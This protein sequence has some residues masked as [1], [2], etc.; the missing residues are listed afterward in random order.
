MNWKPAAI[1]SSIVKPRLETLK[2]HLKM[3]TFDIGEI[4]VDNMKPAMFMRYAR[5]STIRYTT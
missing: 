5:G 2:P 1:W 4:W 3:H